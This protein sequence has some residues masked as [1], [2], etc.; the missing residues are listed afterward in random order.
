MYPSIIAAL[1]A[2]D[3]TPI[4]DRRV[5]GKGLTV[6]EYATASAI[7]HARAHPEDAAALA[8]AASMLSARIFRGAER[9]RRAASELAALS[10]AD[11]CSEDETSWVERARRL[12]SRLI[13]EGADR[14]L[15]GLETDDNASIAAR[16]AAD[17]AKSEG[18][19]RATMLWHAARLLIEAWRAS[20][21][22]PG[23]HVDAWIA[24][25]QAARD[26]GFVVPDHWSYDSH[27]DL[28]PDVLEW[29]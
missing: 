12:P 9:W 26:L 27:P 20:R 14:R 13:G 8:R 15:S 6:G 29:K 2:E 11:L 24:M 4:E 7:E 28:K 22:V 3:S 10:G 1:L 5:V 18:C 23:A 19:Q 16:M 21:D 17:A 25:R